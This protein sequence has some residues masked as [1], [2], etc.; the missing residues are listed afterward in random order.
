MIDWC[1]VTVYVY[2][3]MPQCPAACGGD[4]WHQMHLMFSES[5]LFLCGRNAHPLGVRIGHMRQVSFTAPSRWADSKNRTEIFCA[6]EKG[7]PITDFKAHSH[8]GEE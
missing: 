6:G 8:S 7:R 5:C 3:A 2:E 1:Y 4:G